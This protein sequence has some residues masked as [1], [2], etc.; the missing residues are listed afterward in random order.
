MFF[1]VFALTENIW[2]VV[3]WRVCV[4]LFLVSRTEFCSFYI[5]CCH[6]K[7]PVPACLRFTREKL[8]LF[9]ENERRGSAMELQTCVKAVKAP[10]FY[11]ITPL[12][13]TFRRGADTQL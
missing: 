3:L 10:C 13:N 1:V 7:F 8:L 2:G 12:L 4:S 9:L 6:V 11:V 5:I